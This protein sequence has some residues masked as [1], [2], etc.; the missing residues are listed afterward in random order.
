MMLQ[1]LVFIIIQIAAIVFTFRYLNR[2]NKQV[3]DD[4]Q[5]RLKKVHHSQIRAK[6]LM[7]GL[8]TKVDDLSSKIVQSEAN[9]VSQI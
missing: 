3:F 5:K 8:E 9:N 7:S 4:F 2:R 1:F 6:N